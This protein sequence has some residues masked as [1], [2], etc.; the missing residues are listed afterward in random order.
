MTGVIGAPGAVGGGGGGATLLQMQQA[1]LQGGPGAVGGVGGGGGSAGG[2]GGANR[3]NTME[4]PQMSTED[5][6]T[7]LIDGVQVYGTRRTT[8]IPAGGREG[9]DRPMTTT[10]E[11]WYSKDLRLTVLSTNFNPA[12]GTST[13]KIA[14]LSTSEPDPALFMVPTDYTIVDETE[15]FTITWGEKK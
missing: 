10:S 2:G 7:Q 14:N 1:A 9:N 15:S 12:S 13:N 5:L 3:P 4:R 11:S 8:V 6:G